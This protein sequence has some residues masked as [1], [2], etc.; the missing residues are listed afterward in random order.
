VLRTSLGAW[1]AATV[2]LALGAAA[3][4]PRLA[5]TS[6]A[7]LEYRVVADPATGRGADAAA[8]AADIKARLGAAQTLADVD[9]TP[10]GTVRVVVDAEAATAVDTLLHWRG[11]LDVYLVDEAVHDGPGA[12]D[13]GHTAFAERV[14]EK[15]WR[16]CVVESPPVMTIGVGA[17]SFT[18]VVAALHGRAVALGLPSGATAPLSAAATRRSARRV[19][20]VRDRTLLATTTAEDAS[21]SPL[22]LVFGDDI[23]AYTRAYH[24]R[25][26]LESPAVPRLER[27]ALAQLP[28]RWGL[29]LACALLPLVISLAWLAFVRRFDRARPEPVWLVLATFVLGAISVLPAGLAEYAL[30]DA[31]PWLDPSI[32]T[33]G[34]QMMALPLAAAVSTLVVGVTE[35]G[36]KLLAVWALAFRRREFDEPVDGIVYACAAAL[37]FA[38]AE[39][40]KYF[41]FGRM[42]GS[43]IAIRS[44]LTVPAHMFFAALWGYALGQTLVS[45]RRRVLAFAALAAGAHGLFDAMLSI[46]GLQLGATLLVLGLAIVFVVLL[47]RSLTHGAVA[48]AGLAPQ[49]PPA[50]EPAPASLLDRA[51]WRVGSPGVFYA[52]AAGMV[53]SA[54]ALTVLGT[55]YELLQHR[56][57]LV[58]VGIAST[59]LAVFGVAAYGVSETVPLDA[60]VDAQGLT[61]S[62]ART[63]WRAVRAAAVA[64]RRRRA[65]LVLETSDGSA[66]V[67]P[68]T[69]DRARELL[70]A[71]HRFWRG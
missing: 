32:A 9:V 33:L 5:G 3:C 12:L 19:A 45:R 14:S 1:G 22:Q 56:V 69:E 60:V 55:A 18:S 15:A 62:G 29:A 51:S 59:V 24:A 8:A 41:A 10:A 47:R 71:V 11:G 65:F 34:G 21:H 61:F 35:E 52:S 53:L 36:A 20:F 54:F 43:V 40:V 46:G 28:P 48:R 49:D 50:T 17:T 42:S 37:G 4:S 6:D 26:L 38:A 63:P 13:P 2:A 27:T 7:A 30:S 16:T 57:G 66:R 58:F 44:F 64:G 31:T 25:L 68:T 39:N 23:S 70:A 67:G